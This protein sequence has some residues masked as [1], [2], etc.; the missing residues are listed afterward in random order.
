LRGA[1]GANALADLSVVYYQC[2]F[3]T[4]P[5]GRD[6]NV[7]LHFDG[8]DGLAGIFLNGERLGRL[9][10][11]ESE[12]YIVND[13]LR[14]GAQNTLTVVLQARGGSRGAGIYGSV[15]LRVVPRAFVHDVLVRP[16]VTAGKIA[17]SCDVWNGSAPANA[18]LLFEVQPAAGGAVAK[19]FSH[20]FRLRQA[21]PAQ[22]ELSAQTQRVECEFPWTDARCWTYDDPFLYQVRA[23]LK[24]GPSVVDVTPP[25][26]FGF[27]EFTRRGSE[28]LLNGRPT[29]L[30]G[31]QIDLAWGDQMARLRELKPAGLNCFE[32]SGP[33]THD[34]YVGRYQGR[35]FEEMLQYADTHGLLAIPNLPDAK[36]L[37]ERLFDPAVAALYRRR[38]EKHVR[39]YGNHP[40][41]VMWFM[42]FNLA[43]YPWYIAPSKIDG[44]YKPSTEAFRQK[45][46]Y[47]LAAQRIAAS[48]DERP[49]YHHACGNFGDIYTLNCYIGPTSPLQEREEWPSAWAAKRPFPLVACEHCL[50]LVPYWFRLRRFP[51]SDVYASEPIF[52]ELAALYLGRRAYEFLDA[53]LFDLYDIGRAP[54]GSRLR[55]IIARH[56]GYQE[57]KGLYA[58]RS[59]RAWRTWGVSGIIFNAENWDFRD[60]QGNVLP[61][62]R[63]MAR[64]FGDTDLYIAG[65]GKDWPS[66]D[67]AYYAGERVHKQVVLLNDLTRD[68]PCVLRWQLLDA[69]GKARAAGEI[70]AVAAAG[71]PTLYPIQFSAPSVVRRTELRLRVE[72]IQQPGTHFQPDEFAL[73]VFP[74]LRQA[75]TAGEVLLYDT[76]GRTAEALRRMGV[77][78]RP[79]VEADALSQ[80]ALLV[81]GR[82][83]WDTGFEALAKKA[84]LEEAV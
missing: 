5:R 31:H 13:R 71:R 20:R 9:P 41:V 82:E 75:P 68:I 60:S 27:R 1:W 35:L 8:V 48:V 29:H 84:R 2:T 34:W 47:A 33:V 44:S 42:H 54:R 12:A 16:R 43:G 7:W 6:Q 17:F 45:E 69:A 72:P 80:A 81:V 61:P 70:R 67:H 36:V 55:A 74:A 37:Q 62:M 23:R 4:P 83:A 77:S 21:N 59:L 15:L 39:R 73:Q 32:F 51:L 38:V 25:I 50:L 40:S 58:R 79:V 14:E 56:P 3:T 26:R 46:R 66:K 65:P 19:Q 52:D 78:F 63:A 76:R 57:V 28:F 22:P 24:V 49:L 53:E 18:Q 11:W 30:R 64:Y 10:G